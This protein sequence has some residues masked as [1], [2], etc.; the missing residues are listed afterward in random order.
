MQNRLASWLTSSICHPPRLHTNPSAKDHEPRRVT[1]PTVSGGE[2]ASLFAQPSVPDD[3][4]DAC[5]TSVTQRS[6]SS[7]DHSPN[8]LPPEAEPAAQP[9]AGPSEPN[10]A[11]Q[12]IIRA[13]G[14][15]DRLLCACVVAGAEERSCDGDAALLG[16]DGLTQVV[17]AHDGDVT[18]LPAQ[19]SVASLQLEQCD[20]LEQMG[21]GVMASCHVSGSSSA[22]HTQLHGM[23]TA[24]DWC[25][26]GD[27]GLDIN[28]YAA[29]DMRE[30]AGD[31]DE[32]EEDPVVA[33]GDEHVRDMENT[34][35]D[36]QASVTTSDDAGANDLSD[37]AA[38]MDEHAV[39]EE[40]AAI[41]VADLLA[42]P[43]SEELQNQ[44]RNSEYFRM[45]AANALDPY[46]NLV[47][48]RHHWGPDGD[49][50]IEYYCGDI[51]ALL[52]EYRDCALKP[53]LDFDFDLTPNK[54][55]GYWSTDSLEGD[56]LLAKDVNNTH[57]DLLHEDE[58]R[59][60]DGW[61]YRL[62]T[63]LI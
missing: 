44:I 46:D 42:A 52:P 32:D 10:L 59:A 24:V 23:D 62:Q 40:P 49:N 58:D 17:A 43:V 28:E 34:D 41:S 38:D 33:G 30:M 57:A 29:A 8:T 55:E 36:G 18:E 50:L 39:G 25:F 4:V 15:G 12:S 3:M 5:T 51:T 63:G 26:P 27:D 14:Y 22:Q 16:L 6:T 21:S 35:A 48:P 19:D 45:Q 13:G 9:G 31:Q 11:A 37:F 20:S 56:A 7:Q 61:G 1:R 47:E 53:R 60:D 54:Y 2:T